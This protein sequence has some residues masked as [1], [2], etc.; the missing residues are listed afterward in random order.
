[1]HTHVLSNLKRLTTCTDVWTFEALRE[2][3]RGSEPM[4]RMTESNT[5]FCF[6]AFLGGTFPSD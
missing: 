6:S 3:G 1:M 4:Q 5:M 2:L